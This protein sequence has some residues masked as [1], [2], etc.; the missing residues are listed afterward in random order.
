[1]TKLSRQL[2]IAMSAT[3]AICILG[4]V[5][6]MLYYLCAVYLWHRALE[7]VM[8]SSITYNKTLGAIG[9]LGFILFF[10]FLVSL[11]SKKKSG[12]HQ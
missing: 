12:K 5:A 7:N 1:M 11:M 9:I 6:G 8:G 4:L 2:L 10:A 3:F